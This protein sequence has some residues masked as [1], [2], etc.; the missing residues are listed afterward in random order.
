MVLATGAICLFSSFVGYV[1]IMLNNRPILAIYNLFLWPC[2]GMIAAVGYTAYRKN[3][4]NL[5]GKLS[6]QW[7]YLLDSDGRATIQANVRF[8]TL[9]EF[10][11]SKHIFFFSFIAV[12]TN[13]LQT[14]MKTRINVSRVHYYQVVNSNTKHLHAR[15]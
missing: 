2:F 11:K 1:G 8:A 3:K 13:H 9:G 4:W 14:I 12:V 5:D 7:H 10:I 6:Y 15:H